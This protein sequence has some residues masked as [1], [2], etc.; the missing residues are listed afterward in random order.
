[1]KERKGL[2]WALYQNEL[3]K[4]WAHRGRTLLIAFLVIVLGGTFLV[5]RS[6]QASVS[7]LH[8][9]VAVQK[10]QIGQLRRQV[11]NASG[12]TKRALTSQLHQEQQGLQQM[13]QQT[14]VVHVRPQVAAVKAGLKTTPVALRGQMMETLATDQYLASHGI[15]TFNPQ[16]ETGWRMVGQVFGST[17]LLLFA[18]LAVGISGDRISSEM[19]GGTWGILL[20]HAP[21][22]L[23][24]YLAKLLAS[25][26][27]MW[28]FMTA[29]A[30]GFFAAGS[31]VLGAGSAIMPHVVGLRLAVTPGSVPPQL[32]VPVQVFH[33]LPQWSY[34]L[35]A[36]GLA[37]L[38]MGSL[39]AIA[40]AVSM[41]T[42]STV[43]SLIVG[44]VLV[45]SMVLAHLAGPSALVDPALHLPLIED[46]TGTLA[47]QYD[48]IGMTLRNGL[49]VV[50]AWTLVAMGSS[51]WM[52]RRLDV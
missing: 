4:L 7:A 11:R 36:L 42:R 46:W 51:L 25:L 41:L 32:R 50:L 1:M 14:N 43:F 52:V 49:A 22:R 30:I 17:A 9:A 6:Q 13:E 24:V 47:M 37:M 2:F 38:A 27:V 28:G 44:A 8:Q 35:A 3:E 15:T 21:Q 40:V 16:A 19:E 31:A 18:L 20:L 45:L 12:P 23:Q 10:S 26:T 48:L 39:V 34:D 5:Y 33:I 29:A